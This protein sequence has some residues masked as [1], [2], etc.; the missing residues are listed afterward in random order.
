MVVKFQGQVTVFYFALKIK[1]GSLFGLIYKLF[2]TFEILKRPSKTLS[3]GRSKYFS[4][5]YFQKLFNHIN[6]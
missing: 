4:K 5:L 6:K 3:F 1:R 2:D